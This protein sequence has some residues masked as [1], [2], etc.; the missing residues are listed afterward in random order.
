MAKNPL[1]KRYLDAG[2]AFT[3]MTQSRAEAIV[4]T[5]VSTWTRDGD[6]RLTPQQFNDVAHLRARDTTPTR[7]EGLRAE[8]V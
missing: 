5:S 2:M 3:R 7:E 1:I 8:P 4:N 6:G